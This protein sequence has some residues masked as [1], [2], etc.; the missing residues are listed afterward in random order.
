MPVYNSA[1]LVCW[2]TFKIGDKGINTSH[3]LV[4]RS[5]Y[6][7]CSSRRD[8]K[9]NAFLVYANFHSDLIY[10]KNHEKLAKKNVVIQQSHFYQNIEKYQVYSFKCELFLKK[11]IIILTYFR[12]VLP[13]CTPWKHQQIWC[14]LI[15][16]VYTVEYA[17]NWCFGKCIADKN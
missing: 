8:I 10:T 14:F 1:K 16:V 4:R 11:K 7:R 17:I 6:H 9:A 5:E 2:R 15:Y 3:V 12:P 13:L